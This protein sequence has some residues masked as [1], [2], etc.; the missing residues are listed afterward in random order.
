MSPPFPVLRASAL[1]KRGGTGTCVSGVASPAIRCSTVWSYPRAT[2]ASSS[3]LVAPNPARRYRCP[4]SAR[5]LLKDVPD[6]ATYGVIVQ[7]IH[8]MYSSDTAAV[9]S[10]GAHA[11]Y[12]GISAQ[13]L[14]QV[15]QRPWSRGN[16]EEIVTRPG[17]PRA[18]SHQRARNGATRIGGKK[19]RG[20]RR[21]VDRIAM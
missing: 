18:A 21:I 6:D 20:L 7:L 9:M 16:T 13:I 19:T 17:R 4:R 15:P 12:N 3:A 11:I 8:L 1:L 10:N 5:S 14:E 2:A